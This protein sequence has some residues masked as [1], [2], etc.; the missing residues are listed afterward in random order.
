[1]AATTTAKPKPLSPAEQREQQLEQQRR[2]ARFAELKRQSFPA[3]C[4]Q[5]LH[6]VNLPEYVGLSAELAKAIAAHHDDVGQIHEQ[7]NTSLRALADAIEGATTSGDCCEVFSALESCQMDRGLVIQRITKAW[8]TAVELANRIAAE[9]KANVP[10]AEAAE[11]E[12]R[13]IVLKELEAIGLTPETMPAG[14][15][16]GQAAKTQFELG[17]LTRVPRVAAAG[18]AADSARCNASAMASQAARY[19]HGLEAAKAFMRKTV[20][21]LAGA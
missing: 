12:A 17:V 11:A 7:L 16:N 4:E 13:A 20:A 19:P 2:A 3:A 21:A 18:N 10:P 8:A 1:M 6:G 5:H 9:L 14:R 15:D